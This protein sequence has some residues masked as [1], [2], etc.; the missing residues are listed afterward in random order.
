MVARNRAFQYYSSKDHVITSLSIELQKRRIMF[1]EICSYLKKSNN[2]G[3]R[4]QLKRGIYEITLWLSDFT[5]KDHLGIAGAGPIFSVQIYKFYPIMLTYYLSLYKCMFVS[6]GWSINTRNFLKPSFKCKGVILAQ[7][8]SINYV[9][10]FYLFSPTSA[11]VS[12]FTKYGLFI[13]VV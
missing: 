5:Q 7:G 9:S 13:L 6:T 1:K 11:L 8:P 12:I 3:K 10:T 2:V 4:V